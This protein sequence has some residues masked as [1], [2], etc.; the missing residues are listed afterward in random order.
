M[1]G[2][3][4]LNYN[5]PTETIS[6]I[7]SI[8]RTTRSKYKVYI[9]D[10]VSTDDSRK[11]FVDIY[12]HDSDI[13]ILYANF[14]NGYSSGNNIGLTEAM[15]DQCDFVIISNS[16]VIFTDDSIDLMYD[17]SRINPIIGIIG[18]KIL[19]FNGKI[20]DSARLNYNYENYLLFKKP[21]IYLTSKSYKRKVYFKEYDYNEPLIFDGI[22]SG[23][24][25][26]ITKSFLDKKFILDEKI[27]LY[28]EEAV[29]SFN[30]QKNNLKTCVLPSSIVYHL[31]SKSIGNQ[32]NPFSMYHRYYSSMYFLK[33]YCGISDFKLRII[34]Y[35]N[36]MSLKFSRTK[37]K[38]K[39]IS[40]LKLKFK[41]LL[42]L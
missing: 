8:R 26:G 36:Y 20:Q 40:D 38:R 29:I 27:F 39:Y 18:P 22:V 17:F 37:K 19:T 7:E 13:K 21:F 35:I 41:E 23:C 9:I 3:V 25:F 15:N 16:D 12:L 32:K 33:K 14:N 11:Q 6:C 30:C 24:C 42:N 4:I 1:I 28:F 31:E 34:Y 2:I 10:N 5:T